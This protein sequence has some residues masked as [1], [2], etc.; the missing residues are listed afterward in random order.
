MKDTLIY[1]N[2]PFK[3][4]RWFSYV[5]LGQIGFVTLNLA[6]WPNEKLV[7]ERDKVLQDRE[8]RKLTGKA[9]E[10]DQV[11]SRSIF[12][13]LKSFEYSTLF[14]LRSI[15]ENVKERPKSAFAMLSVTAFMT[16]ASWF[17]TKRS[18]HMIKLLPNDRVEFSLFSML[19]LGKPPTLVVPL[20]EVSCRTG[21]KGKTNYSI[22]KIKGYSGYHLVHKPDGIFLEPKLYDKHLGYSR[23]WAQESRFDGLKQRI[24]KLLKR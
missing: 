1:I 6:L 17:M 9:L 20:R 18:I 21:R 2:N 5:A 15:Y 7:Y 22:L 11:E 12:E 8:K 14:T 13:G 24:K 19:A 10:G 3:K 4:F 16:T 23:N